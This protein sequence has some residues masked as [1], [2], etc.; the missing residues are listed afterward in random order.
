MPNDSFDSAFLSDFLRQQEDDQAARYDQAEL[1]LQQ[2]M[3][4]A[5]A[6][7]EAA[8]PETA[9]AP[10]E[11]VEAPPAATDTSVVETPE[12]APEDLA[13]AT[14]SPEEAP[15]AES[16]ESP[17]E[18]SST[19]SN[20]GMGILGG[21]RDA[22]VNMAT[23]GAEIG[24][25]IVPGEQDIPE[26]GKMLPEVEERDSAAFGLSKGLSQFAAGFIPGLGALSWLSRGQK[27]HKAVSLARASGKLGRAATGSIAKGMVAGGA[28]D[29]AVWSP[30]EARLSDLVEDTRF[31]NPVTAYLANDED[32]SAFE[33]RMKNV[34]EGMALGGLA[35]TIIGGAIRSKASR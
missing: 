5:S 33:G 14:N 28:A 4:A 1:E 25:K 7:E 17:A 23:L 13:G 6:E 12:T 10:E 29:L 16:N 18:D 22:G 9:A 34:L 2:E 3:D 20:I 26:F 19:W 11:D 27:V 8:A 21:L 32:D 35:D 15:P 30:H 31:S 24:E